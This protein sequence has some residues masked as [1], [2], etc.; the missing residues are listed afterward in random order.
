MISSYHSFLLLLREINFALALDS[1]SHNEK[2]ANQ[3]LFNERFM[4]RYHENADRFVYQ[5]FAK[6]SKVKTPLRNL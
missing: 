6:K 3:T 5:T 1:N 4:S 2:I